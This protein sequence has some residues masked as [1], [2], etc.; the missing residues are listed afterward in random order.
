MNAYLLVD[1]NNFF[2]SCEK[3]FRPDLAERP[4][5]VLSNN[6]G[7]VIAR[8]KEAKTLGFAMGAPYFKIGDE[9]RRHKV[10][11][12]SCNHELYA[13]MSGRVMATLRDFDPGLEVYSIDE[14]FLHVSGDSGM[15]SAL[16][17]EIRDRVM[18]W[19]GIPVSVGIAPTKTLAKLANETAKKN[20]AYHGVCCLCD[21]TERVAAMES[22]PVEDIWGIGRR[23]A[24]RLRFLGYRTAGELACADA[25]RIRKVFGVMGERVLRELQGIS[26]ADPQ[27]EAQ[28]S[29]KQIICSRSFGE[30]VTR[31]DHLREA[32]C[33]FIEKAGQ[34]LRGEGLLCGSMSVFVQVMGRPGVYERYYDKASGSFDNPTDDTRRLIALGTSLLEGLWKEGRRYGK[35]GVVLGDFCDPAWMQLSFEPD[36]RDPRIGRLMKTVDTLKSSGYS[37][38]FAAQGLQKPWAARRNL[39]S[40]CYTTRWTD[41]PIVR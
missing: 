25:G 33:M 15:L 12:C 29:R 19:V 41:L 38:Q 37:I 24:P 34:Q 26:C 11:I 10:A 5:L 14:A 28:S 6:D 2:A 36:D 23:L 39:L 32:T 18:K 20:D 40:P 16:G 22:I 7:C 27:G 4:L 21:E 17:R 1:C 3:L 30:K 31:Y 9:V 8:S 13:E 35:S